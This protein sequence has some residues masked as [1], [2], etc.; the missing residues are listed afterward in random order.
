MTVPTVKTIMHSWLL[1]NGFDGLL[2]DDA[3]CGCHFRKKPG[4]RESFMDCEMVG[5]ELC[6]PAYK[7]E[8]TEGEEEEGYDWMMTT[9]RP[10]VKP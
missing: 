5:I 4:E 7:R 9:I 2:Q 1:Q 10:E 8:P 3:E 6:R